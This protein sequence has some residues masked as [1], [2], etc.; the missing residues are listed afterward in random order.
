MHW[1]IVEDM[2]EI[3][4]RAFQ[5]YGRPLETMILFKYLGQIITA[6]YDDWPAVVGNL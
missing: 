3:M 1:L 6:L 5:A 4:A 2:R